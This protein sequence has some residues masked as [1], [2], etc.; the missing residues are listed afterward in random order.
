MTWRLKILGLSF[1]LMAVTG[2]GL[3]SAEKSDA[4]NNDPISIEPIKSNDFKG[5]DFL[6][7][8]GPTLKTIFGKKDYH[9]WIFPL[10]SSTKGSG[11]IP[12]EGNAT[13]SIGIDEFN[14]SDFRQELFFGTART[15]NSAKKVLETKVLVILANYREDDGRFTAILFY[16]GPAT[17]LKLQS[18]YIRFKNNG[19]TA[20]MFLAYRY[21]THTVFEV[22]DFENKLKSDKSDVILPNGAINN[23]SLAD[24]LRKAVEDG[25]LYDKNYYKTSLLNRKIELITLAEGN[26][27]NINT[28]LKKGPTTAVDALNYP[29]LF[30]TSPNPYSVL[31]YSD[32]SLKTLKTKIL[33][34]MENANGVYLFFDASGPVDSLE[35]NN[36]PKKLGDYLSSSVTGINFPANA[37]VFSALSN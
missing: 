19:N 24:A 28:F 7:S 4:Q 9:R 35:F 5:S 10:E 34:K 37:K 21:N 1:I 30:N 14:G 25:R 18:D 27:N 20:Q 8:I 31:Y 15:L 26:I 3:P 22:A 6:T 17:S 29:V 23:K 36:N 2:C 33:A 32:E 13:N 12:L 11:I 16:D